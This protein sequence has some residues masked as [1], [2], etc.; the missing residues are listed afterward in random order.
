[1]KFLSRKFIFAILVTVLSFVL[2]VLERV[3]SEQWLLFI[4]VIGATYVIGNVGT[5]IADKV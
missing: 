4:E 1:M 3:T 2:L 5:K